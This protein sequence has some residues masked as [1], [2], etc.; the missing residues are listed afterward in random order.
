MRLRK[1]SETS[2]FT[3][4]TTENFASEAMM[5]RRSDNNRSCILLEELAVLLQPALLLLLA[6]VVVEVRITPSTSRS[7]V[8]Q[9]AVVEG[10][11]DGA[12]SKEATCKA[13]HREQL[14]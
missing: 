5:R 3:L 2:E 14:S 4:D 9:L 6:L 12:S 11:D 8:A 13:S 1:L 10:S 7:L